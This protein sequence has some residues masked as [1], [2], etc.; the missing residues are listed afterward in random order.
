MKI[1]DSFSPETGITTV[2]FTDKHGSYTG[3]AKLNPNDEPSKLSGYNL[4]ALRAERIRLKKQRDIAR[5]R[6]KTLCS[7]RKELKDYLYNT[8]LFN[9]NDMHFFERLDITINKYN[10]ELNSILEALDLLKRQEQDNKKFRERIR[11]KVN[12]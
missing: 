10:K 11:T 5:I 8:N 6:F 4:A 12:K 2:T 3:I 7:F 1:K 9:S